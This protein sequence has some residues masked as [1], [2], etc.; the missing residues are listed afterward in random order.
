MTEKEVNYN[1][2]IFI[3]KNYEQW[4]QIADN[5]FKIFHNYDPNFEQYLR[6][7]NCYQDRKLCNQEKIKEKKADTKNVHKTIKTTLTSQVILS[8]F[9]G[10]L[11][12]YQTYYNHTDNPFILG[13]VFFAIVFITFTL[14]E[15]KSK[16]LTQLHYKKRQLVAEISEL[17][18]YL[19]NE[20]FEFT[21]HQQVFSANELINIRDKLIFIYQTHDEIINHEIKKIIE[22]TFKEN[23]TIK[24]NEAFYQIISYPGHFTKIE[25]LIKKIAE[26]KSQHCVDKI[27]KYS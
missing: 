7:L 17:D 10:Y 26:E 5:P 27:I 25:T 1:E 2:C 14:P 8:I 20:K 21:N 13:I 24:H 11:V 23:E 9:F 18:N 22:K 12:A 16:Y 6:E 4:T 3:A 19:T 15:I